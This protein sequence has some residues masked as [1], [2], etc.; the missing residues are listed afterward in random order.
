VKFSFHGRV[1][2]RN[3]SPGGPTVFLTGVDQPLV[4]RIKKMIGTSFAGDQVE[5]LLVV[6]GCK[7]KTAIG[8]LELEWTAYSR[9]KD[10]IAVDER[11]KMHLPDGSVKDL[12][13]FLQRAVGRPCMLQFRIIRAGVVSI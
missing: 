10:E 6:S 5:A 4:A 3:W 13:E 2:I 9:T 12:R 8:R 1:E 11:L 7:P